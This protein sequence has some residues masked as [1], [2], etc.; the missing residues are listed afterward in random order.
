MIN[1][2]LKDITNYIDFLRSLGYSVTLSCFGSRFGE[3]LPTLLSYEVHLPRIC[4]YL[5]A[6]DRLCGKCI[7][8]K[9]R[10][11]KK[12]IGAPYY[13][14]CYAGIEEYIFPVISD[15]FTVMCIHFSG[16]RGKLEIS[17]RMKKLVAARCDERFEQLYSE[18]SLDV[19][20]EEKISAAAR[21]L[22]YM[23]EKLYREC[24][25]NAGNFSAGTPKKIF[26]DAVTYIYENY[27]NPVLCADVAR[28]VNYSESYLRKIFSDECGCS[29]SEYVTKIRMAKAEEMLKNTQFSITEIASE[30]GFGDA[31]YFS[32]LFSGRHGASPREYRKKFSADIKI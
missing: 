27:M 32:A 24:K 22:I 15:G 12:Q 11:E 5:K 28:A 6:N 17:G 16:Y 9:R 1:E 21:P 7:K 20:A 26:L 14:C 13:S 2:I 10:L 19:P 25:E 3:C 29:V 23:A 30:C 4:S 18:L 8:N 31:N